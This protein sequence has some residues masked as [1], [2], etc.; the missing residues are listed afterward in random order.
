MERVTY[1]QDGAFGSRLFVGEVDVENQGV[2]VAETCIGG[3]GE[4][5]R[6]SVY[7]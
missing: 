6:R 5:R 3:E 7:P 2:V 1:S 4:K